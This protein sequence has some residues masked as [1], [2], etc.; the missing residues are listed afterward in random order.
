MLLNDIFYSIFWVS[1]IS[2]VWF[3]TDWIVHYMQLLNFNKKMQLSYKKF[4]AENANG[5]FPDFL[6]ELSHATENK[7]L[8][9]GLKLVSCPFCLIFWLSGIASFVCS[10]VLLTAPIYVISLFIVLQIKKMM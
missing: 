7:F 5:Y 2:I 4:I 1:A 6:Y 10:N 8:K 3:C 9:F